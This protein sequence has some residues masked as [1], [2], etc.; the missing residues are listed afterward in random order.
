M[1]GDEGRSGLIMANLVCLCVRSLDSATE[2]R[3]V[4]SVS[5]AFKYHSTVSTRPDRCATLIR[6]RALY[7]YM[8]GVISAG[9]SKGGVG[10]TNSGKKTAP[11]KANQ[12]Q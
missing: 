8:Q 5:V 9:G 1:E 3:V 4:S 7:A 11:G 2:D 10:G 6:V 12:R